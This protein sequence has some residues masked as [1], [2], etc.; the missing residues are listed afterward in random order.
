MEEN[1]LLPLGSIV[2]LKNGNQKLLTVG[3]GQLF[4]DN[5]IIGYYEYSSV[6]YPQGMLDSEKFAFSIM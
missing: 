3:R 6:L 4:D 5:G 1:R 2:I